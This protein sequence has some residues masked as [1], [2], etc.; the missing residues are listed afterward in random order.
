MVKL[1]NTDLLVLKIFQINFNVITLLCVLAYY[2]DDMQK[3]SY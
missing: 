2:K 1:F 3:K